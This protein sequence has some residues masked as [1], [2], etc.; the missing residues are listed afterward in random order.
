M[1]APGPVDPNATWT[2]GDLARIARVTVRTL[3]H[4]DEIGLLRP[5]SFTESGYRLYGPAELERLHLVRLYR[6]AGV[7]LPDIRRILDAPGFDRVAA[8]RAHRERLVAQIEETEALVATLDRLLAPGGVVTKEE[9]F[10]GFQPEEY[11]EEARQRWGHTEAFQESQRRTQAYRPEDWQ[12]VKAEVAAVE[13]EL[14]ACLAAGLP[15]SSDRAM[16]A[17]ERHRLHIDRWF[18]PCSPA[19]HVNLGEMY[20]ADPRFTAH[21][22]QRAPGLAAYV[23]DAIVANAARAG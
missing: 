16:D 15:A 9:L 22:D 14:A 23:R 8:L 1:D 21:Y 13:E 6:S 5:S 12:E 20:V 19:F 7:P 17:A 11:A 10:D 4:Y 18:Y 2:V 3:H